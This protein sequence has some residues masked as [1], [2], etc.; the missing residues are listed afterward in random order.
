M[1][2]G[3]GALAN[4]PRLI[5]ALTGGDAAERAEHAELTESTEPVRTILVSDEHWRCGEGPVRFD[6]MYE[7]ETYDDRCSPSD[8]GPVAVV[9]GPGGATPRT[10]RRPAGGR[11]AMAP[12]SQR[13]DR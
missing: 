11:T 8:W 3:P 5:C 9:S 13:M 12:I 6:S 4:L 10:R 2:L 1:A 7:G